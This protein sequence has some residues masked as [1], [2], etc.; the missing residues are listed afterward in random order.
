[1]SVD[2]W[3]EV[4]SMTQTWLEARG[5]PCL[6]LGQKNTAC[7]PPPSLL[8]M[9]W[10]RASA[11]YMIDVV[12]RHPRSELKQAKE[13]TKVFKFQYAGHDDIGFGRVKRTSTASEVLAT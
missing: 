12:T 7:L 8:S 4:A 3:D 2:G 9:L 13:T 11:R 1:M 10:L 5:A 6:L